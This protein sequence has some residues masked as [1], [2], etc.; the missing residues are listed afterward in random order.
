V[1]KEEKTATLEFRD[2]NCNVRPSS[3]QAYAIWYMESEQGEREETEQMGLR[4]TFKPSQI[5]TA[6]LYE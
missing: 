4:R 1:N 6:T 5:V 2:T 3:N